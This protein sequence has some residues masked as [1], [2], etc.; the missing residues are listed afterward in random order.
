MFVPLTDMVYQGSK[1]NPRVLERI[2]VFLQA[3][4]RYRCPVF[5]LRIQYDIKIQHNTF[6]NGHYRQYKSI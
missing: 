3:K 6:L 2:V 4:H 5:Q 1:G